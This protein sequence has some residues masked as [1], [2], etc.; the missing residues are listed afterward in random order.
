MRAVVFNK[1]GTFNCRNFSTGILDF[2]ASQ[3]I[4]PNVTCRSNRILLTL[5]GCGS[6]CCFA[7]LLLWWCFEL[8]FFC[9]VL[10]LNRI[11][12]MCLHIIRQCYQVGFSYLTVIS[13]KSFIVTPPS[14]R[15]LKKTSMWL[16]PSPIFI[17]KCFWK[18]IDFVVESFWVC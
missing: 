6:L 14:P 7:F 10:V 4:K 15:R 8:L 5:E 2:V 16:T 1:D 13:D 9:F 11:K 17:K 12:M 18:Q 3:F